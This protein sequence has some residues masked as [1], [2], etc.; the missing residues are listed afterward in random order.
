[1]DALSTP[2]SH[3]QLDTNVTVNMLEELSGA[4]VNLKNVKVE[5]N[6]DV[7]D[8]QRDNVAVI[9]DLLE[10]VTDTL[11]KLKTHKDIRNINK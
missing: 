2:K 3:L 9:K 10:I 6:M 7:L 4:L 11:G 1:M 5:K 8:A